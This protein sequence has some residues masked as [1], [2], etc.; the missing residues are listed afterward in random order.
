MVTLERSDHGGAAFNISS[1]CVEVLLFGGYTS[2]GGPEIADTT[3]L[4]FGMS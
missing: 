2:L 1:E 4:R 3:I